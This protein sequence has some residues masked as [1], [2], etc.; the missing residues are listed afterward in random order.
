V[1][2]KGIAGRGV[3]LDFRSYASRKGISYSPFELHAISLPELLEIAAQQRVTFRPGDILLI[4]TGWMEAYN[5]LT[6]IEKIALGSRQQRTC[7]GI[8]ASYECI[9]WHW[10]NQFA[11]VAGD[12]VAYEVWPS[13]KPWGV[14]IH[15]VSQ[16]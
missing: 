6:D 9:K 10:D 5:A 4:R 8:E 11:A 15:E 16:S 2:Q 14:A 7:C 13:P 1:A 3:L 12:A